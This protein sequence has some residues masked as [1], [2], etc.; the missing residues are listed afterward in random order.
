MT[1]KITVVIR[2]TVRGNL[3]VA[4]LQGLLGGLSFG[5]LGVRGALRW[6]VAMTFLSLLPAVGAGLV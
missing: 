1:A 5:F 3:L 6:A 4:A 2:A